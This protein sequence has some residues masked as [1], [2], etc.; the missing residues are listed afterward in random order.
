MQMIGRILRP[1][2]DDKTGYQK[3]DAVF[4]DHVNLVL[5]HQ[6]ENYPGMPL[7]YVPEITW[8]FHGR[9]K[10]KRKK[11]LNNIKLCPLL[12][13]FYCNK[14]SCKGCE[15]NPDNQEADRRK[16]MIVIPAELEEIKKPVGLAERPDTEKKEIYDS[17]S[18]AVLEYKSGNTKT[19]IEKLFDL[20]HNLGYNPM[21]IYWQIQD[22]NKKAINVPL[23]HEI[24][25]VAGF[26]PGWVFFK[27]KELRQR[28]GIKKE[29][30]EVMNG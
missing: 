8:N 19:A 3:Q 1:F 22:E 16:P 23:L 4:M 7:H 13:F 30:R 15:H 2:K 21:W 29:F 28:A 11:E 20:A 5:E 25:R 6:D 18:A 10:R 24:A 12:D 9:E 17:I 14:P 27:M 26:K